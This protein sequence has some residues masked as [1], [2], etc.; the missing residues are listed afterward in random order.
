MMRQAAHHAVLAREQIGSRQHHVNRFGTQDSSISLRSRWSPSISR[1]IRVI[2][3]GDSS[4]ADRVCT[5]LHV[6][7]KQ[8]FDLPAG[9]Q[10]RVTQL[11]P[12]TVAYA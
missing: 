7:E 11:P 5:P 3:S 2:C 12:I 1:S 8:I 9:L 6:R 10:A 4:H